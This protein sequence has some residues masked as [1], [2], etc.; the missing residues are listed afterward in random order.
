MVNN[1]DVYNSFEYRCGQR[2][3][4]LGKV[5]SPDALKEVMKRS[6]GFADD[7]YRKKSKMNDTKIYGDGDS[8]PVAT[9]NHYSGYIMTRV[10]ED[11]VTYA[12]FWL[13]DVRENWLLVALVRLFFFH[14]SCTVFEDLNKMACP[15][16]GTRYSV[17]CPFFLRRM[18]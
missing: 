5:S 17:T 15:L 3:A 1:V 12:L 14:T 13:L 11:K 9:E 4:K 16:A 7:G 10:I 2:W 18:Y 8:L 6:G